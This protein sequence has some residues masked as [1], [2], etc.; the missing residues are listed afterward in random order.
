MENVVSNSERRA[1]I[2]GESIA[3]PRVVD[4]Y[5]ALPS[6]TGKLELEYEGELKGGESVA[7]ELVRGAVGRVFTRHYEGVGFSQVV[8][9]FDLGG[10]IRLDDTVD[11]ATMAR[12][13]NQI[14]GLLERTR[15]LG[16]TEN[17]PDAMRASAA[18]FIL[19]GLCAHRRISR[20]EERV[21]SADERKREA[22][23]GSG[24]SESSPGRR[25]D[26][27]RHYQ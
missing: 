21:F 8:Q 18:E 6:M 13:L 15:P 2:A 23:A 27:R 24:S 9:W 26:S 4:I 25:G 19:E 3:V 11:S 16:L 20:S 5:A 12:E 10:T 1:L 14:Q 7:R 22:A 17:E